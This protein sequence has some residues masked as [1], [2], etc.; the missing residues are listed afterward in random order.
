M[1]R[2]VQEK[3]KNARSSHG[4]GRYADHSDP[5][6]LRKP[7]GNAEEIDNYARQDA[8]NDPP[9]RN[10]KV[11]RVFQRD[12]ERAS[13]WKYMEIQALDPVVSRGAENGIRRE[14]VILQGAGSIYAYVYTDPA[15]AERSSRNVFVFRG[16]R[17][18]VNSAWQDAMIFLRKTDD[19]IYH[20]DYGMQSGEAWLC[21]NLSG[22]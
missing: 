5:L 6:L 3:M 20:Y 17:A 12:F 15:E 4:T 21:G 16:I 13:G 19:R 7:E 1:V 14:K 18:Q 2:I 22:P 8:F 10:G 9:E 11:E